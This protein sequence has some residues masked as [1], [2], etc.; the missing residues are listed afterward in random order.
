MNRAKRLLRR[1]AQMSWVEVCFRGAQWLRNRWDGFL[2]RL[3]YYGKADGHTLLVDRPLVTRRFF[4]TAGELPVL[5][6]I[7]RLRFPEKVAETIAWA[8]RVCAHRFDLLGYEDLDFGWQIDWHFDPV[9]GKRAPRKLWYE[10]PYL[11]FEVVGDVKIIWELSRHN[12]FVMLGRA[13]QLTGAEKYAR[14]FVSQFYDWQQ[15]NPNPVGV[16]WA[17]S[18]EVAMRS[19]SWLWAREL[20]AGSAL[21]TEKFHHDLLAALERNGRFIERNLSV[22]FSPNT[23]LLGEGVALFFIGMLCPELRAACR[24][25]EQ[26]WKIVLEEARRQVRPDGGYFE[27]STYYHV[28]ALDFLL[29]ARGLAAW[30]QL[31]IP[32][33]FDGTI[34]SMLE[35]LTAL[36]AAGPPPR[37]GDDDGGRVFEAHR[38]CS[39]H[40]LDP[41]S[42]GAVLFC[43]PDF[44]AVVGSLCE[45]TL[46]L[47]GPGAAGEFDRLAKA[48][49]LA[50]SRAFPDTG[51]YILA[52]E[53]LSLAVD[54]GPLG[55][56]QGGH[57]HADALSVCVTADGCDWLGDPGTFTYT[58][59]RAARDQ[60]RGTR[61]HNTMAV[62]GTDQA[63]PVEP[64]AW[65]RFPEVRVDRWLVGETFDL[66]EAFHDGYMRL[67]SPVRHRRIVF[68]VKDRFWLVVDAAQGEGYHAL[69]ISW[70]GL[71]SRVAL[72]GSARAL[73]SGASG[74]FAVLPVQDTHWSVELVA[75]AW[76]PNYGVTESR[77]VL[78]CSARAE[79]PAEFATLLM[80]RAVSQDVLG[81]L[82]RRRGNRLDVRGYEYATI[83]ERHL[84][85]FAESSEAWHLGEFSSDAQ[86]AYCARGTAGRIEHVVLCDASFFA[87]GDER[88][89]EADRR[90]ARIEFRRRGDHDETVF[91]SEA[92]PVRWQ[93]R[94]NGSE[95]APA[96]AG[97]GDI[98]D[99]S[100]SGVRD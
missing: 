73:A 67:A 81:V 89:L 37:F 58:G 72:D 92:G 97:A 99:W 51:T 40:L 48:A 33:E 28:Y 38:N 50:V 56:A 90:R 21:M 34:V 16:N 25:Q 6:E 78:R 20:F 3:G 4:F 46:W 69:E 36:A 68:F 22:Y 63:E 23:H 84:W 47:L 41:L 18:L 70:H 10:I 13:Y 60:F 94:E 66:L 62:D 86:V 27:Q 44:K 88:I 12:H 2:Y 17:S 91:C 57:G 77:Q 45:E 31:S 59:S 5:T 32:A 1:L 7:L 54:A 85:V 98:P 42:T 65:R 52:N 100:G 26:G 74:S 76:S 39:E 83:S 79:L 43:R 49:P 71:P 19:L 9:H 96:S 24:W 53:G 29:H 14:E 11:D 82:D 35:Y 64:F 55:A 87:V 80:P 75:A 8:E 61:A 93:V 15:Q 95:L 30:N